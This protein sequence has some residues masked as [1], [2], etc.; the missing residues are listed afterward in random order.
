MRTSQWLEMLRFYY[1][2][3]PLFLIVDLVF[4]FDLRVSLPSDQ[5]EYKLIYYAICFAAGFTAFGSEIAAASFSLVESVVNLLLLIL[6]VYWPIVTIGESVETGNVGRFGFGLVE[7][8]HFLI[9]GSVLLISFYS[10]PLIAS[11]RA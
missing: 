8:M 2:V 5:P 7:L 6:T 9:V 1:L 3:T 4:G 11:R 10:N